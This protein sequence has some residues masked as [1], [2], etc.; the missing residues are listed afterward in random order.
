MNNGAC[1]LKHSSPHRVT[2]WIAGP[3]AGFGVGRLA[4][5]RSG[6]ANDEDIKI[7]AMMN[8]AATVVK[9]DLYFIFLSF[10]HGADRWYTSRR[11]LLYFLLKKTSRLTWKG[12]KDIMIVNRKSSI[13]YPMADTHIMY[14]L[15]EQILQSK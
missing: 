6:M 14:I 2:V 9:S 5:G 7:A 11:H 15:N 3:A 8:M 13:P 10:I 1:V 4:A 12:A